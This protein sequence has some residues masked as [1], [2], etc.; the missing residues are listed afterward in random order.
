MTSFKW[1]VTVLLFSYVGKFYSEA[2]PP[3][4]QLC[5]VWY[6]LSD[7]RSCLGGE[8]GLLTTGFW[9]SYSANTT[10]NSRGDFGTFNSKL[11]V[12][13]NSSSRL[14][15]QYYANLSQIRIILGVDYSIL[16][17]E[18]G[19]GRCHCFEIYFDGD[20]VSIQDSK[21]IR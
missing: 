16:Q 19:G 1:I 15:L 20:C 10:D 5:V 9:I 11:W 17:P 7:S 18:H 4:P 12:D 8:A 21:N 13:Y 2:P 3:T 14:D 6:E